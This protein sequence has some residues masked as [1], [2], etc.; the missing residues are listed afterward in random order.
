MIRIISFFLVFFLWVPCFAQEVEN[1]SSDN[2]PKKSRREKSKEESSQS[3]KDIILVKD[4]YTLDDLNHLQADF[5]SNKEGALKTLI[6][7]YKDTRF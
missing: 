6:E 5:N 7:I 4:P 1:L 2:K 3:N